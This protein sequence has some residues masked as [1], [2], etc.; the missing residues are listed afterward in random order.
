[1]ISREGSYEAHI[2]E[3]FDHG[4]PYTVPTFPGYYNYVIHIGQVIEAKRK[5]RESEKAPKAP[6]QTNDSSFHSEI[7]I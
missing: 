4:V 7:V 3:I 2:M 6:L 5:W 1:M